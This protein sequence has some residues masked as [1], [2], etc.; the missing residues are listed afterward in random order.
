MGGSQMDGA[1]LLSVLPRL[2]QRRFHLNL[3]KIFSL[4]LTEHQNK[5]LREGEESPLETFRTFLDSFLCNL[6]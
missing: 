2:E 3:R 5:L 1:R 6:L 4:R